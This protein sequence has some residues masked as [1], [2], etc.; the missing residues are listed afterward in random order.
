MGWGEIGKP[1]TGPRALRSTGISGV[2]LNTVRIWLLVIGVLLLLIEYLRV[3]VDA[4]GPAAKNQRRRS[5][6]F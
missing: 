3:T 2:D 1:K 6:H 4:D 5:S